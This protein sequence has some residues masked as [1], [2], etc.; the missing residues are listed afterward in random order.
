M[1]NKIVISEEGLFF[2]N[3]RMNM[4][5][6]VFRKNLYEMGVEENYN[7]NCAVFYSYKSQSSVFIQQM[8]IW[9][10]EDNQMLTVSDLANIKDLQ[11]ITGFSYDR[12]FRLCA[13]IQAGENLSRDFDFPSG[14]EFIDYGC[15]NIEKTK[16]GLKCLLMVKKSV[17]ENERYIQR[18]N[19]SK[20]PELIQA[21]KENNLKKIKGLIHE[22]A[23]VNFA[24]E[25]FLYTPLDAAMLAKNKQICELLIKN[26]ARSHYL[27]S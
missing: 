20:F 13:D 3:Q 14:F 10:T 7:K 21:I 18:K 25:R 8:E 6:T 23:D 5:E 12:T 22:G 11:E 19:D 27:H 15:A 24:E 26:G 1:S 16:I 17:W 2:N 9:Y 4:V